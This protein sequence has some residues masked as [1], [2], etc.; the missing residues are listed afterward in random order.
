M[1][2]RPLIL[3][4]LL[5]LPGGC[6][7]SHNGPIR[8]ARGAFF[9]L[10]DP[11]AGPDFFSCQEV[12]F[13]LPDGQEETLITAVEN[14]RHRMSVV[15]STPLGQTLFTVQITSEATRVDPRLPLPPWLDLR[16]VPAFVQLANWPLDDLRSG[17]GP[18]LE[19]FEEGP[20]RTLRHR[21]RILLRL[22]REGSAAP[23][24][25]V[26][27]ELPAQKVHAQITTLGH[28]Y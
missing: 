12:R 25:T 14:D 20:V 28:I 17:L 2:L 6:Q 26:I 4:P 3:I 10:R 27:L 9:S 23:F 18:G 13:T 22:A 15:A 1:S 11:A 8:L 19:L 16:L 5:L 21:G 7:P 24:E